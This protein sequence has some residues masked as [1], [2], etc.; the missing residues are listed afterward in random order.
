MKRAWRRNRVG[1][2]AVLL[3][4]LIMTAVT[5][6]ALS[7]GLLP[8]APVAPA[9]G[10]TAPATAAR[11]ALAE[12]TGRASL[13]RVRPQLSK[14]GELTG[15]VLSAETSTG[16]TV[17]VALPVESSVGSMVGDLVVYTRHTPGSGSEV[18]ALSVA[19]G[20]DVLLAAPSQVVR[21]AIL[22][23]SAAFLYVH[24]VARGTRADAGVARYD[25]ASGTPSVVVP[26]LQPPAAV[27]R[28]FGTELKWS[29][30]GA[31][32]A[33]QSCGF[34]TCLTRIL[35][36]SSGG[37]NAIDAPGQG[38]FIALTQEHLVTYANCPGLSCDVLSTDLAT[39][40]VSVVATE[41]FSVNV[42]PA[43]QPGDALLSI[44]TSAGVLE[45]TQ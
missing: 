12:G 35:D 23:P 2:P 25:L 37:V 20:C 31:A 40:E 8:V 44:E 10:P 22:D 24:S 19:S 11:A 3:T 42:A 15:R 32:L 21:S 9:C 34:K 16:T 45:V 38:A 36:V 5:P 26:P 41:A 7:A 14:R 39:G 17:S 13:P 28:I 29:V 30:S 33:V 4:A 43:T 6:A 18:R 27:G 1:P